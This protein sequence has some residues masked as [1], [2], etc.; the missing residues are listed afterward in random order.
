LT[1]IAR[2]MNPFSCGGPPTLGLCGSGGIRTYKDDW[3]AG[4]SIRHRMRGSIAIW[5]K[6]EIPGSIEVDEPTGLTLETMGS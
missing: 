3:H 5:E 6:P 2:A 1:A 4:Y